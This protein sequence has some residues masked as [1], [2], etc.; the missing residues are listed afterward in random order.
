MEEHSDQAPAAASPPE[1]GPTAAFAEKT[2]HRFTFTGDAREYFR[3]WI[4]NL[5]L[6]IFTLGIYSAWAKVRT[7]RY[8]YSNTHV[9]GSPFEY[10]A[11]P[12][13]ILKGRLIAFALLACYVVTL[14]IAPLVAVGFMAAIGLATPWLIV[15]GLMFRARYSSWRGLTFRF[16]GGYG[17]AYRYFLLMYL[18]VPLTLGF[19]WPYIKSRQKAF[20][21]EGHRY[22]GKRFVF[23]AD[24]SS[25]FEIYLKVGLCFVG[26]FMLL[27]LV[28]VPLAGASR[29]GVQSFGA[30][31]APAVNYLAYFMAWTYLASR[32]GNLVYTHTTLDG[33]YFASSLRMRDLAWIYAGNT[34]AI[35]ASAGML[36]PW[37]MVR[38]ARYRADQLTLVAR[39]DLA[40]FA[41]GASGEV[42]AAA[43]EVDGFFDVD[44]GL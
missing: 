18:L 11:R 2:S 26:L 44:I 10:L 8:F 1:D 5:A 25:F 30:Y 31:V 38:L 7:Q 33:H 14:Q 40:G 42:G 12:W 36:I 24:A 41:G 32:I 29:H 39:N 19:I 16:E 22:G 15:R 28:L 35:L 20:V 27:A 13:P 3:I 37:A 6:G 4:V 34:V 21:I 17:P 43:S 9:A 23:S